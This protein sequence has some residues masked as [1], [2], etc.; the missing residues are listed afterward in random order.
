MKIDKGITPT[1]LN[2]LNC[3]MEMFLLSGPATIQMMA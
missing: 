3:K 2:Y 1:I